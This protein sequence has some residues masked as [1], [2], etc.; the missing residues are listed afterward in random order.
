MSFNVG[1]DVEVCDGVGRWAVAKGKRKCATRRVKK[2]FKVKSNNVVTPSL[3]S[4]FTNDI[5]K[6]S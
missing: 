6:K 3:H 5:R 1:D 2:L 4:F